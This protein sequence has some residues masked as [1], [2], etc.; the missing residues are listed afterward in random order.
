[1]C[2]I[3]GIF[4]L[5]G[6][7]DV[8]RD[9]LKAMNDALIHRGP[10]GEGYFHAPGVGLAHR[11]LAVIDP[12]DGTQPFITSTG[13]VLS[14]NG[15]V[16][17]FKVLSTSLKKEG[18]TLKTRS[19]TEVLAEGLSAHDTRFIDDVKGMFAFAFYSKK[20]ESLLLSRDR[21]GEK[22][23]Y[24]A[25]TKDGFLM[26]ASEVSA[27]L[28]SGFVERTF[29]PKAIADYFYFGFVP[30]PNTIYAHVH[31]LEA[32][33]HLIARRGG[34]LKK[35][36]YW[37]LQPEECSITSLDECAEEFSSRFANI[38]GAQS[39]ADVPLGAF[40][41]SGIDSALVASTLSY[42][43][44][45]P[46]TVTIGFSGDKNDERAEASLR[47]SAIGSNHV[48]KLA[49]KDPTSLVDLIASQFGEPFADSAALSAYLA[50]DLA[51]EHVT[52]ALTG[53]G[54]D[55]IFSGYRRYTHWLRQSALR[56]AMPGQ[57]RQRV[58]GALA[59]IYPKADWAPRPLRFQSTFRELAQSPANAYAD[60]LAI[61]YPMRVSALFHTDFSQQIAD[62]HPGMHVAR[63]MAENE[64]ENP[65]NAVLKTDITF[66]LPGRMLTKIDRTSMAV[67]LETRQPFLDH[68][69]VNWATGLPARFRHDGKTGKNVL[70]HAA[71]KR[72]GAAVFHGPKKGFAAPLDQWFQCAMN[73]L[74]A[75]LKQSTYW[76]DS[77]VLNPDRVN[78]LLQR[79]QSGIENAGQ[80]LW[81]VVMFDAFL[82]NAH[83]V[84]SDTN[85][86]LNEETIRSS[87]C[88]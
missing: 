52:V 39:V 83:D 71:K 25:C 37:H 61:N 58:F 56:T 68:D 64:N 38:I 79:H 12:A 45:A 14:Y 2:G 51:R 28:A 49:A 87:E 63:L 30:E 33:H 29:D 40:L 13:D 42:L 17:N 6:T 86:S 74:C 22:P 8:D 85:I 81:S 31:K 24:Y 23:L 18:R 44:R 47:A 69:L 80:E 70:R 76:R 66:W 62:Y 75:R 4:D 82:R 57:F 54:A 11:R 72:F 84:A 20:S 34:K 41:S 67:G 53:D 16:Y 36:R 9:A 1:M 35:I 60:A 88:S 26:F 59:E 15:E 77:G 73:P 27:L 65:L 50:A 32:G 10:D 48:E 43:D 7:R 3:A 46:T 55:E 5:H 19:D 21:F 78:A